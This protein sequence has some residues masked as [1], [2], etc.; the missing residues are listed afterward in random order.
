MLSSSIFRRSIFECEYFNAI[1]LP[2]AQSMLIRRPF[3]SNITLGEGRSDVV[4]LLS[5]L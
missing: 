5:M 4:L 3:S 1:L 2:V